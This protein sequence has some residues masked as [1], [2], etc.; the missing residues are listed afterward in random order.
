MAQRVQIL[1]EDDIDGTQAAQTVQFGVDGVAY[2]IDLSGGH[3]SQLRE[4]LAP[5]IAHARK[6]GGK[7]SARRGVGGT[8]KATVGREQS[9]KIRQWGRAH[10]H[11]V[12]DRGRLPQAVQDAYHQAN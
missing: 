12:S 1:M 8:G 9:A 2:E 11:Q 4:G 7:R 10:G 3:A 6:V 5:W